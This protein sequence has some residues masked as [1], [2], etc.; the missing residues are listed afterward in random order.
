[1]EK[2]I[3]AERLKDSMLAYYDCLSESA[4]GRPYKGDT[5]MDYEVVDMIEDCIDNAPTADVVEACWVDVNDRMPNDYEKVLCLCQ[6][7]IYEVLI[8]DNIQQ[9]WFHDATHSYFKT[10]VTHWMP[11]PEPPKGVTDTNVGC[12]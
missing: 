8:W 9:T 3:N 1:M 10:F 7:N 11:L 6:A 4:N 5:L 12:K 2:Y